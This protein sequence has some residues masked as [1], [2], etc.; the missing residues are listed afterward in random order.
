MCIYMCVC[1]HYMSFGK[2]NLTKLQRFKNKIDSRYLVKII[3]YNNYS[4]LITMNSNTK[5]VVERFLL[6]SYGK[7]L[8]LF[9]I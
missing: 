8:M 4:F 6:K 9:E 5:S 2:N 1:V 3:T 7:Q